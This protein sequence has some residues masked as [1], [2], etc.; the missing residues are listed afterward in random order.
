MGKTISRDCF[1]CVLCDPFC[2]KKNQQMPATEKTALPCAK[3]AII[4]G[5][6]LPTNKKYIM[7][8]HASIIPLTHSRGPYIHPLPP[9]IRC[10]VCFF[11]AEIL[12]CRLG[13]TFLFSP[14]F[15]NKILGTEARSVHLHV[16]GCK[17][18]RQ[19]FNV[20]LPA[21]HFTL[22]LLSTKSASHPVHLHAA[23]W[24]SALQ[25]AN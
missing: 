8:G 15:L 18:S 24:N 17:C 5:K 6:E 11:Y 9:P 14:F 12:A 3:T 13:H 21:V 23:G 20:M 1:F 25:S 7:R 16:V 2:K 4:L 19:L 22:M 10:Q